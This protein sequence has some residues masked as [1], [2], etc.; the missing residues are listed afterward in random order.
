MESAV[1]LALSW[2]GPNKRRHVTTTGFAF[3]VACCGCY[4]VLLVL[5]LFPAMTVRAEQGLPLDLPMVFPR[6]EVAMSPTL[7]ASSWRQE[8]R[9][10]PP[11]FECGAFGLLVSSVE[12][13]DRPTT[14]VLLRLNPP[15]TFVPLRHMASQLL[16][17]ADDEPLSG[18]LLRSGPRDH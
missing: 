7:V 12:S 14:E 9:A 13:P 6:V 5:L 15:S 17:G 10:P 1:S 4:V 11:F 2:R 3:R 16:S 8:H 18:T